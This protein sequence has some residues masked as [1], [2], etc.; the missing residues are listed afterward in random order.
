MPSFDINAAR[1]AGYSDAEIQQFLASSVAPPAAALPA[2]APATVAASAP[3]AQP[4]KFDVQGA[5]AAGYSDAEIQKFLANAAS[6]SMPPVTAAD[7]AHAAEGG[8]LAGTAY[9]ATMIP[10]A[11]ANVWNLGKSALGSMYSGPAS[12]ESK[13]AVAR[14]KYGNGTLPD[15]TPS[16]IP[17][18]LQVDSGPSPV[19]HWLTQQMDK[20]PITSTQPPRPDDTASRYLAAIGTAVPAA[21][22]GAGLSSPAQTLAKALMQTGKNTAAAAVPISVGQAVGESRPFGDNESA[23]NA[24]TLA[25]QLLAGQVSPATAALTRGAIRGGEA[26][27]Q[28]MIDTVQSFRDLGA[29]PTLGQATGNRPIQF[30][31]S[32]LSKLPGSAGVMAKAA[33]AQASDIGEGVNSLVSELSP[34]GTSPERA[35]RAISEG[36][37]GEGGF[38]DQFRATAQKLYNQLDSHIPQ[39]TPVPVSNTMKTLNGLS[40]PAPGATATSE[41]L[42]NSK[43]TAIRKALNADS[44][45]TTD[46]LTNTTQ[47]GTLPYSAL[48]RIRSQVGGMLSDNELISDIPKGQLKQLYGAISS[49][50]EN[51]ANAAGPKAAQA[52]SRANNYY[53]A[54]LDRL[55]TLSDVVNKGGPESMFNAALSGTKDGA[56]RLR[57][58]MQSLEPADQQT[59]AATVLKRMG[60]AAPGAQD[61]TGSVF[62]PQT[63]LT[64]WNKMSPE[65]KSAL[66]DR[67]P[68]GLRDKVDN[69]A[70]V[71]SNLR[72][73]SKVF[74]NP[75]GTAGA[76]HQISDLAKV[77]GAAGVAWHETGGWQVPAGVVGSAGVANVLARSLTSPKVVDWAARPTDFSTPGQQA[78]LIAAPANLSSQQQQRDRQRLMNALEVVGRRD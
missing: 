72:D 71:A 63:F 48:S 67:F 10:D 49:D 9:L 40:A 43:I 16:D 39:S 20:N 47:T 42:A 46:S 21:A 56:T 57:S 54:G 14:A 15:S 18:W 76:S 73:G 35:G 75:S 13:S 68:N 23:N 60:N 66:F 52:F 29:E 55:D 64:N 77:L 28:N 3:I 6:S 70:D 27:R 50:M 37:T 38:R 69:I 32:G 51:A 30:V 44:G 62:S 36:V 65:A 61:A 31:E 78:A 24:A 22:T 8:I 17:S 53:K 12:P 19:G 2:P 4:T 58:V 26:G 1:A 7:R 74:S 25:A 34:S 11:A 59:V 41:L 33:G 5:K 45:T